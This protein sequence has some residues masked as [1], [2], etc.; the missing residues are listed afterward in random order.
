M[1][2][3]CEPYWLMYIFKTLVLPFGGQTVPGSVHDPG[4]TEE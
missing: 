2:E 4:T 1:L 3:R